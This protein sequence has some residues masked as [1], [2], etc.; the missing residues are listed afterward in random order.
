MNKVSSLICGVLA[1]VLFAANGFAESLTRDVVVYYLS[2]DAKSNAEITKKDI[3]KQ[4]DCEI[5]LSSSSSAYK[6]ITY[7]ISKASDG[8]FNDHQVRVRISDS[9]GADVYV[10]QGGAVYVV[11]SGRMGTLS[12]EDFVAVRA[13]MDSLALAY[14]C[15]YAVSARADKERRAR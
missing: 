2:F 15:P 3:V 14:H 12:A 9:H 11:S 8:R 5:R 7:L 1:C 6:A 13:L 4:A 10:E